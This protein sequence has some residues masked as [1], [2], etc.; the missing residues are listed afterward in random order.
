MNETV[1]GMVAGGVSTIIGHPLDT[2]KT[3]KQ[4]SNLN[5]KFNVK[6]LLRGYRYPLIASITFNGYLFGVNNY[7]NNK[8]HINN[9]LS[10]AITGFLVVCENSVEFASEILH[11]FLANSITAHCK[12]K[13]IP[14][15][16]ILF[17]LKY[18]IANIFPSIPL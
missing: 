5:I 12:P 8:Y 16:G 14:K 3:W 10:G 6:N 9:F 15:N 11:S 7:I 18:S 2:I 17:F 13:H 1:S 4:N